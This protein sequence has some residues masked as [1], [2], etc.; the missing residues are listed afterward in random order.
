MKIFS[1]QNFDRNSFMTKHG[2]AQH[3]NMATYGYNFSFFEIN[4]YITR[5]IARGRLYHLHRIGRRFIRMWYVIVATV[6]SDM[7]FLSRRKG[8]V[9]VP[10]W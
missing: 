6:Q 4:L 8:H 10:Y 9:V 7:L 3:G 2:L 5:F 1:L